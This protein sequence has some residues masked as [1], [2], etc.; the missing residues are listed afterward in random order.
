MLLLARTMLMFLSHQSNHNY[1]KMPNIMIES[2]ASANLKM[3]KPMVFCA[4]KRQPSHWSKP[5]EH[6]TAPFLA[7]SFLRQPSFINI[8]A[9]IQPK[10]SH[11]ERGYR[12]N[13]WQATKLFQLLLGIFHSAIFLKGAM[14]WEGCKFQ[15]V[16]KTCFWEI[17]YQNSMRCM[18]LTCSHPQKHLCMYVFENIWKYWRKTQ[19]LKN[20]LKGR[21]SM[22]DNKFSITI[23]TQ[24]ATRGLAQDN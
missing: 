18:P 2:W 22:E 9:A 14:T 19:T 1:L 16:T 24:M 15:P 10:A 12:W 3:P 8:E 23:W 7:S 6:S 11:Q 20:T 13:T 21:H 17:K 5:C 4:M